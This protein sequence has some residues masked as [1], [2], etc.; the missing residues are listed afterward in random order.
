[1]LICTQI[2]TGGVDKTVLVFDR[3][4]G[5]EKAKLAHHSKRV[6]DVLFHPTQDAILSASQDKTALLWVAAGTGAKKGT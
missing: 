4:E 3:A 1:M 5:K 6:T 2:A